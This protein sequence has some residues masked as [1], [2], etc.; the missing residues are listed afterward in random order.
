M[1]FPWHVSKSDSENILNIQW[2]YEGRSQ[3]LIASEVHGQFVTSPVFSGRVEHTA[4]A[5][6]VLHRVT[7]L[8]KGNYSV[9]VVVRD[10]GGDV[11]VQRRSVLVEV[12]G[13]NLDI[14]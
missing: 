3:E 8:D 10:S 5:E 1:V 14:V 11:S 12:S 2:F 13:L 7:L 9:E 6:I 4:N